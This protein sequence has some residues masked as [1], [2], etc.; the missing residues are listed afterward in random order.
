MS[1]RITKL[2][3]TRQEHAQSVVASECLA[4]APQHV[5]R[6]RACAVVHR[7]PLLL[8]GPC[9]SVATNIRRMSLV[10]VPGSLRPARDMCIALCTYVCMITRIAVSTSLWVG[11]C[12]Q[13]SAPCKQAA[14]ALQPLPVVVA[15]V[16]TAQHVCVIMLTMLCCWLQAHVDATL[17]AVHICMYEL[18]L[19]AASFDDIMACHPL[20]AA[21][22]VLVLLVATESH[23]NVLP[24]RLASY[25][26]VVVSGTP[27]MDCRAGL[28]S[29]TAEHAD[30][31]GVQ[32][33][34]GLQLQHAIAYVLHHGNACTCTT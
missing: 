10:N 13:Q 4:S 18:G 17:T 25:V 5:H 32:C 29:W 23:Y 1:V 20:L 31:N 34:T 14:S 12:V 15:H 11:H 22:V 33:C 28:Q 26:H 6:G 27:C 19:H 30:I 9:H 24:L 2:V 7:Q 8:N 21:T 3:G 16:A